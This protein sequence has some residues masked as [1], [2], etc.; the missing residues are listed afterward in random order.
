[1]KRI[2]QIS[3]VAT[4]ILFGV[5]AIIIYRSREPRYQGRTLSAWIDEGRKSSRGQPSWET[6]RNAV[7]QM[8][9]EVFPFLM[10][11][12]QAV[13]W[14][15][16]KNLIAWLKRHPSLPLKIRSAK[17]RHGQA[18]FAFQLLGGTAKPVQPALLKLTYAQ[19]AETRECAFHCLVASRPDKETI[20]PVF[21]RLIH[22]PDTSVQRNA[23]LS[24][25]IWYRQDAEA[26]GVY[27][28]FPEFLKLPLFFP[29]RE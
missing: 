21:L 5:L 2:R 24:F 1:M 11:D 6:A 23:A 8:A 12:I 17:D 25:C 14:P 18:N 29:P 4:V 16:K 9:P 22:D 27:K 20:M 7:R 19:D 10:E 3:I 28:M 15:S 13:D 26:A